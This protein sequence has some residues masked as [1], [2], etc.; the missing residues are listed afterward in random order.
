MDNFIHFKLYHTI[1]KRKIEKKYSICFVEKSMKD[2]RK[3][4]TE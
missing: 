1:Q 4:I 2:I 3:Y